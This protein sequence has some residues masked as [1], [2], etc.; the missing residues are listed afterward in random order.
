MDAIQTIESLVKALEAGNPNAAPN[1]LTQGAALQ[2]EDLSPVMHNVTF[3]DEH[4]KLTKKLK[5]ETVKSVLSQFDRQLSYGN[6]GDSAQI[7]GAVGQEEVSDFVRVV[8]PMCYYSHIRRVTLV[9]NLVQTVDGKKA[10]ARAAEDAALKLAADIEFDSFR[11]K[12]DFTNAGVF[13]GNPNSIP[14][15]PNVLGIDTQ[16]RQSD[17]QRQARDLM[18]AEYG[19]DETVVISGG[20]V[21][22]QTTIE[23]AS[24]RSAM[25]LGSASTLLV[26]P[27][28]LSAYNKIALGKERIILANSPQDAT[29]ADLRR[30]WVSGGVVSI[31]ASRFLSG[32]T[33][34]KRARANGPNVPTIAA[35]STGGFTAGVQAGTTAFKSGDVYKYFVSA[36]NELG[37][38]GLSAV[39]TI[40]L[41]ADGQ[42]VGVTITAPS[43]TTRYYNVYRTAAGGSFAKY[44]GRTSSAGNFIDLGNKL[45]GF[46]TGFLMEDEG[47][48]LAELAPYSRLKLA[49]TDLS[50]PE[51]HFRFLTLRGYTP[52]KSVLIDNLVGSF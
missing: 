16:I 40:T 29:G 33:G 13:D 9:A 34:P 3:G 42:Q 51:A 52:R 49:V 41:T 19:S 37:E 21:L 28:V 50:Q 38:S 14:A 45:P 39:A 47:W 26:D 22:Q 11:G 5:V 32:K 24:V 48:D 2:V 7:E 12:A 23:D 15:L 30:Q 43:G 6:F 1:T 17:N 44:I 20:G 10:E 4:L 18:L 27:K 31:E 46:V 36:V 35:A 25:N 8:V